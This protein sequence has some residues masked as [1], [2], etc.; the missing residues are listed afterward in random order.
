MTGVQTCAL[1]ICVSSGK[2]WAKLTQN[3]SGSLLAAFRS[4]FSFT[5]LDVITQPAI[6]SPLLTRRG[7]LVDPAA[8]WLKPPG[9]APGGKILLN[10]QAF[11][12]P[13]ECRVDTSVMGN[14]GRNA[15]PGPGLFGID[16]SI[17]RKF[18]LRLLGERGTITLR[19][20]AFNVLNHANLNPPES[21]LTSTRFGFASFG[22]QGAGIGFPALSPFQETARHVQFLVRLEF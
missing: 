3:W 6:G 21:N 5:V 16:A 7:T 18:S 8:A 14:T 22:R 10:K 20:D 4:G 1:P 11:C 9:A 15:F 13:P 2:W 12:S 17:N 19:A